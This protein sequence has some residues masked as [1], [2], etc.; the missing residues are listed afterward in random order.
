MEEKIMTTAEAHRIID[1]FERKGFMVSFER[2]G[3]GKG[4]LFSDHFPDKHLGEPL[5]ETEEEAWEWAKRFSSATN[6][7][8]VNIYVVDINFN[9]VPGYSDKK[10]KPY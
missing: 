5:I 7:D 8:Y 4:M 6:D 1:K 9:P 10:L 3:R 2:K